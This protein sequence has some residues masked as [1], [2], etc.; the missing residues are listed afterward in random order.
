MQSA[1]WKGKK[2]REKIFDK[3]NVYTLQDQE[4]KLREKIKRALSCGDRLTE[5]ENV[6]VIEELG[7][8]KDR[9]EQA[10]KLACSEIEA[11]LGSYFR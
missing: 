10:H 9:V 4:Y 7:K 8:L 6:Q 3:Y 2:E 5:P 1:V 11:V